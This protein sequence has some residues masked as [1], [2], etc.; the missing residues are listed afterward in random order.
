M[1]RLSQAKISVNRRRMLVNRRRLRLSQ[2]GKALIEEYEMYG[3]QACWWCSKRYQTT[4][5]D[6]IR[7]ALAESYDITD[8]FLAI[9]SN[10]REDN[11]TKMVEKHPHVRCVFARN[12]VKRKLCAEK[13]KENKEIKELRYMALKR[14][15]LPEKDLTAIIENYIYT[16]QNEEEFDMITS[17][18]IDL[19]VVFKLSNDTDEGIIARFVQYYSRIRRLAHIREPRKDLVD[20]GEVCVLRN[21]LENSAEHIEINVDCFLAI[22]IT[23]PKK[24]P[25]DVVGEIYCKN[26]VK[27]RKMGPADHCRRR[28]HLIESLIS[29]LSNVYHVRA[30]LKL[31]GNEDR[32]HCP[33]LINLQHLTRRRECTK[34]APAIHKRS[35][36]GLQGLCIDAMVRKFQWRAFHVE[37]ILSKET[38]KNYFK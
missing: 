14:A 38:V 3:L 7:T 18:N 36:P 5:F 29:R 34:E 30:H 27:R 13:E 8:D 28:F 10:A 16:G 20:T 32:K 19:N 31:K 15:L 6:R 4:E 17:N 22:E 23:F 2:L 35:P 25:R 9:L 12:L 24:C 37:E 33:C 26:G 21:M 11:I 1:N